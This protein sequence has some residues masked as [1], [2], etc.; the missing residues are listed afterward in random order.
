MRAT[1][2]IAFA[3]VVV[4]L[5]AGCSDSGEDE[6]NPGAKEGKRTGP[7]PSA[8]ATPPGT[9]LDVPALYDT[10]RGWESTEEGTQLPLPRTGAVAVYWERPGEGGPDEYGF[11]VL[12][13]ATGEKRWSSVPVSPLESTSLPY[14]RATVDGKEYLALW[15]S[16]TT[17]DDAIN[18]GKEV[19]AIDIFPADASGD[20]VRPVH[21][22]VD[23]E[24]KVRDGGAGLLVQSGDDTVVAVDPATGDTTEYG[25]ADQEPPADCPECDSSWQVKGLTDDGLLIGTSIDIDYNGFWVPGAWTAADLRPKGV[26]PGEPSRVQVISDDLLVVDWGQERNSEAI[27]WSAVD[28]SSGKTLATVRCEGDTTPGDHHLSANG[29]YLAHGGRVFD[30]E[31]GTGVCYERTDS[32]NAVEFQLATDEGV[33]YGNAIG[34]EGFISSEDPVQL[35]MRTGKIEEFDD[36]TIDFPFGDTA[37][38]GLFWDEASRTMVAYPHAS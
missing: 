3:A 6:E 9:Q 5:L 31:E 35:D 33:V 26:A 2:W 30:L 1:R 10:G 27:V 23:G 15:S 32:T 28:S 21:V 36:V 4:A 7:S 38:F 24:G 20:G 34:S 22:E 18:R 16:G 17:D 12:D 25:V 19:V 29:R 13:A 8:E 11:T 14:I 37:G